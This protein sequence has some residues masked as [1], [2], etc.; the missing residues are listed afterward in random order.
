MEREE[1]RPVMRVQI[2]SKTTYGRERWLAPAKVLDVVHP[3]SG[4][5]NIRIMFLDGMADVY[6]S[7]DPA[8]LDYE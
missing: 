2:M 5:P 8:D 4:R 7:V 6:H 3:D 1:V